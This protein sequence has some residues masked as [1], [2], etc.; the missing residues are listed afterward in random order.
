MAT[1]NYAE[2][3]SKYLSLDKKFS[4]AEYDQFI[5]A[6][7]YLY[8]IGYEDG[9]VGAMLDKQRPWWTDEEEQG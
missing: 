6:C 9:Y 2:M 8:N 3:F 7:E 4:R 1:Y 5:R